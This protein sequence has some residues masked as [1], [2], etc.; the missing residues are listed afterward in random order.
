[1]K[2]SLASRL[3]CAVE[4]R[5]GRLISILR[6]L[7]RIP[8]ENTPPIGAEAACQHYVAG[9][10]REHGW[11]PELYELESV[12]GFT[13]HP[14][15]RSGRDYNGR[16]NL[17][18]RKAGAGGGRSLLLSGHIDTVPRGTQN[19]TR[20]P[21]GAA[22]ENGRLYGRGSND[23][24]AGIATNLFMAE[25]LED[26]G[27]RLR[28]DL[29]IETVVDEEFGGTSG[30][31]AGRLKGI[32]ADAAVVSEPTSLRV[33]TA[34]RG[35]RTVHITLHS[36]GGVLSDGRPNAGV[37][38]QLSRLLEGAAQFAVERRAGAR[39]SGVFAGCEDPVPV[40]VTKIVTAPWGTKE[41]Q[42]VSDE[43]RV[44]IYWQLM[45]GEEQE[46]VDR[47][48]FAWFERLIASAPELFAVRPEVEFPIRFLPGSALPENEPVARELKRCASEVLGEEVPVA[49]IEGPCDLFLFHNFGIPAVLWGVKGGNTHAADEYV[50]L[51]S[52]VA[53]AKSLLAFVGEW[54]GVAES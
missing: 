36:P 48:F 5:S 14:H 11:I 3:S 22:I 18:A 2:Q 19:W 13:T 35:G 21:F 37:I 50:D 31:L 28:G 25:V 1:M 41:P 16:P 53:A 34:Q 26:L 51:D 10:L 33:C 47:E 39:V 42:T 30:T 23:M 46:A 45:P 40:W 44:E 6:D 49:G 20:D 52:A 54:C 8:S 43:C 29:I 9:F 12:P 15:Y 17:V 4:E 24:K 38:G 27:L 7:V 32:R